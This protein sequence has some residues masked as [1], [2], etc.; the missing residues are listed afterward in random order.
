MTLAEF[1]RCRDSEETNNHLCRVIAGIPPESGVRIR[2][3]AVVDAAMD[4][5]RR[6]F[7]FIGLVERFEESM[8]KLGAVLGVPLRDDDHVNAA[9][10]PAPALDDATLNSIR[11]ENGLDLELFD[12]AARLAGR[13]LLQTS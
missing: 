11:Y 6:H 8:R 10:R 3:P 12:R 13:C 2:D 9:R 4:N 5:L 1:V 7:V